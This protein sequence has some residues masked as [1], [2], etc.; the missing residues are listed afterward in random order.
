MKNIK[1][2]SRKILRKIYTGLGLTAIAMVFQACYGTPQ[3]MGLDVLIRGVVKSKTTDEPIEGIKVSAKDL[4]Q[5]ELTDSG[6][7]FQLYVPWEDV[8]ILRFEDIDGEVN[9]SYSSE[10]ISVE[11]LDDKIELNVSLNAE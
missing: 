10:E 1:E 11:L 9:G 6:G 4:Y 7:K 8:C 3:A 2:R 5:Y